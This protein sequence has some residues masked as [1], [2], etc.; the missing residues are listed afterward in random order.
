[1]TNEDIFNKVNDSS[2]IKVVIGNGENILVILEGKL[3]DG[4]V[5]AIIP[6][7]KFKITETEYSLIL[8]QKKK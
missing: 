6:K 5:V 8:E 3:V 4:Q 7:D 2:T 1:M